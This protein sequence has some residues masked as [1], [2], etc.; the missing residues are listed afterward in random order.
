MK[1]HFLQGFIERGAKKKHTREEK[2]KLIVGSVV[3]GQLGIRWDHHCS[4]AAALPVSSAV[5]GDGVRPRYELDKER[6]AARCCK[7]E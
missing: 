6:E 3:E 2:T 7:I 1:P 5:S 4:H